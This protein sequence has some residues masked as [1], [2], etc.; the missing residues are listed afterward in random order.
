MLWPTGRS[1]SRSIRRAPTSSCARSPTRSRDVA[2]IPEKC[3]DSV[4]RTSL[5][6]FAALPEPL[7]RDDATARARPGT[8]SG[9]CKPG[10]TRGIAHAA[11]HRARDDGQ[12]LLARPVGI[13]RAHVFPGLAR[14]RGA[15][16]ADGGRRRVGADQ[17]GDDHAGF[18]RLSP[19]G[20]LPRRRGAGADPRVRGRAALA[21]LFDRPV[22]GGRQS[23][24]QF[25][26]GVEGV[27]SASGDSVRG[28]H[29]ESRGFLPHARTVRAS[30][31][32]VRI[33]SG[34]AARRVAVLPALG[35][36]TVAR[37]RA[38]ARRAQRRVS[39][40]PLHRALHHPVRPVRVV[41]PPHG[42]RLRRRDMTRSLER[43]AVAAPRAGALA[44]VLRGVLL[45]VA[46]FVAL[47]FAAWVGREP[48]LRTAADLW[49]VSD[50][51]GPADAVAIFGGGLEDRP[52][53]AA[54][55]YRQGLVGKILLSNIGA[56]PAEK[57]GVL[58]S[59]VEANRSV[60]RKLGVPDM[61]IEPFGANL[62]NTYEEALALRDWVTR[63]GARSVIVPT[64]I[65]S[66]RR[67]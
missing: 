34:L 6:T 23:R 13:S 63:T 58:R 51:I 36:R 45:L 53:A 44:L 52:F 35:A 24:R 21:I 26:S 19:P 46:V 28:G 67:G 48:L 65:F 60:L 54:A 38:A 22:G 4:S 16:Q 56:S 25:Q 3:A 42:A 61:A 59:H 64:E 7:R 30:H 14:Y 2:R 57:L 17:A 31:A 40:F 37:L 41:L 55:Y 18:R 8:R 1:G 20:R 47:A 33:C 49:I 32:L 10:A 43:A 5:S 9:E 12:E 39:R 11:R 62:T 66:A 15:L 29:H 27:L 50:E